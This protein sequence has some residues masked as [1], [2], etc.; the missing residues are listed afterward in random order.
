[1]CWHTAFSSI[2]CSVRQLQCCIDSLTVPERALH[3]TRDCGTHLVFSQSAHGDSVYGLHS[4]YC[5]GRLVTGNII[6]A[7]SL[8]KLQEFKARALGADELTMLMQCFRRKRVAMMIQRRPSSSNT[9]HYPF[10]PSAS[11]DIP[12]LRSKST[13]A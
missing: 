9:T 3:V 8:V 5:L 12:A 4:L 11:P 6:V 2:P 7:K 1:M 13:H 10:G